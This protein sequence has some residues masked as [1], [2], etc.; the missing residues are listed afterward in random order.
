[1]TWDQGST[2]LLLSHAVSY[3]YPPY[4]D[5]DGYHCL[6]QRAAIYV[7]AAIVHA[8]IPTTPVMHELCRQAQKRCKELWAILGYSSLDSDS[9]DSVKR[10]T[11]VMGTPHVFGHSLELCPDTIFGL[12]FVQVTAATTTPPLPGISAAALFS[13]SRGWQGI[14]SRHAAQSRKKCCRHTLCF[15]NAYTYQEG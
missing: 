10:L 14:R 4:R 3:P 11:R 5:A 13:F 8:S 6:V 9:E 12:L 7:A 1:M 2:T 15:Q